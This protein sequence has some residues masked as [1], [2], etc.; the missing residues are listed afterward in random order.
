MLDQLIED[1]NT[2]ADFGFLTYWQVQFNNMIAFTVFLAWIKVS[3]YE[4]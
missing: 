2:F 4:Y 1:Q 3:N